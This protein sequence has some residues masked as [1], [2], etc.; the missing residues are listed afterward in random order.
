MFLHIEFVNSNIAFNLLV[1]QSKSVLTVTVLAM[2]QTTLSNYAYKSLCISVM[3]YIA[4]LA[5]V[6]VQGQVRKSSVW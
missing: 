4:V 5:N 6:C 1:S 3:K 2:S